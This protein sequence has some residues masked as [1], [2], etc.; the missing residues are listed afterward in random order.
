MTSP[1]YKLAL[2]TL[3]MLALAG[4]L[5]YPAGLWGGLQSQ[6]AL[7]VAW[8]LAVVP[9]W[10]VLAAHAMVKTPQQGVMLA[11]GST[12]GRMLFVGLGA[13][14]VI[15]MRQL[16]EF[17]FSVWIVACYLAALLIETGLVL[18]KSTNQAA[19]TPAGWVAA[20]GWGSR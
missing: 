10:V 6:W 2:F 8:A 7:A 16:P 17:Q 15:Q 18:Q 3:A 5:L 9:G 13:L 1:G 12:V 4:V 11:L 14:L 19:R 20:T